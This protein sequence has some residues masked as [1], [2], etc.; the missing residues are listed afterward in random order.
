M[1]RPLLLLLVVAAGTHAAAGQWNWECSSVVN[2]TCV[3]SGSHK[4]CL[5]FYF[6]WVHDLLLL[7]CVCMCVCVC[8]CVFVCSPSARHHPVSRLSA[9][10]T[11]VASS[12][13][14]AES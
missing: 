4:V 5:C 9:R 10:P 8:V 2:D 1:G 11:P 12:P 6:V 13:P 3:I 7:P 14:K